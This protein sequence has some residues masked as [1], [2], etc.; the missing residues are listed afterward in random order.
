MNKTVRV[1][2]S[3]GSDSAVNPTVTYLFIFFTLT[4]EVESLVSESAFSTSLRVLSRGVFFLLLLGDSFPFLTFLFGEHTFPTSHLGH[5]IC[6][7]Q[8]TRQGFNI[9]RR[10][11]KHLSALLCLQNFCW[12]SVSAGYVL[13]V[14]LFDLIFPFPVIRQRNK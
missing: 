11:C 4:L 1:R 12:S 6:V 10:K 3:P 8:N 5:R 7:E 14:C 13:H 9:N 2:T